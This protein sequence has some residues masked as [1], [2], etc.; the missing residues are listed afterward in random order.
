MAALTPAGL[1]TRLHK[2]E[3][4]LEN[5]KTRGIAPRPFL[6]CLVQRNGLEVAIGLLGAAFRFWGTTN[7]PQTSLVSVVGCSTTA[8][9][10]FQ[11]LSV[12]SVTIFPG[13]YASISYLPVL[14]PCLLSHPSQPK[15]V[16][17]APPCFLSCPFPVSLVSTPRALCGSHVTIRLGPVRP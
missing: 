5:R 12:T 9:E 2:K 7:H 17:A 16:G 15:G 10:P 4:Q 3:G 8:N 1:G 14:T 6:H 13:A 11:I